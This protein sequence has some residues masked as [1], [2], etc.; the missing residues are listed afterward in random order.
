M[1]AWGDAIGEYRRWLVAG[2]RPPTTVGLRTWQ[3][4]RF[5]ET[6]DTYHV[7]TAELAAY[8]GSHGWAP[9]TIAST[10]A[11]FCSFWGWL[12]ASGRMRTNPA[13]GLPPSKSPRREPR[14]APDWVIEQAKGDERVMLMIDLAARQGLRRA[15]VA[16]VHSRDLVPDL[17]GWSLLVHGKGAK[18]RLIPLHPD[19]AARLRACGAGWVFP[20][21]SG[22]HLCP[23]RVGVLIAAALPDGWT[24]HSLRRRFATAMYRGGH[25]LKAVQRHLGHA[26]IATTEAYIGQDRERLRDALRWVC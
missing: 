19:I 16:A 18:D 6:H 9:A 3:V 8:L 15:E 17:D 7:T 4:R 22:G 5:A 10:R 23:N 1:T 26:S 20:S 25:D 13:K 11:A 14:P 12:Q 24:A 2:G 21:P